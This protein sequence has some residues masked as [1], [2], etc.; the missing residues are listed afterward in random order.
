MEPIFAILTVLAFSPAM[1]A[2]TGGQTETKKS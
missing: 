1:L 2:Q